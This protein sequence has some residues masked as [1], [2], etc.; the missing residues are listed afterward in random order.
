M[1]SFECQKVIL[2]LHCAAAE[3]KDLEESWA[4]TR[5]A[6]EEAAQSPRDPAQ[7]SFTGVTVPTDS[8]KLSPGRSGSDDERE[9]EVKGSPSKQED[10]RA[11]P[12]TKA[13]PQESKEA[14]KA[15]PSDGKTA[16]SSPK[17]ENIEPEKPQEAKS[18]AP[19]GDAEPSREEIDNQTSPPVPASSFKQADTQKESAASEPE[20]G[21]R[22]GGKNDEPPRKKPSSTGSKDQAS[23]EKPEPSSSKPAEE[24]AATAVSSP[25]QPEAAEPSARSKDIAAIEKEAEDGD[26]EEAEEYRHLLG[27]GVSTEEIAKR[28]DEKN[29][30]QGADNEAEEEAPQASPPKKEPLPPPSV[31]VLLSIIPFYADDRHLDSFS[32]N[33]QG[34]CLENFSLPH[35]C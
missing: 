23:Q 11:A 14:T 13:A 3:A 20:K 5:K 28:N 10:E 16:D 9:A 31:Q 29:A 17:P 7:H 25:P 22:D 35:Y 8:V 32:S 21:A 30:T 18:E 19:L 2:C 15:E 24:T 6:V 27:E 34:C 26:G 12:A 33:P 4:K 1:H